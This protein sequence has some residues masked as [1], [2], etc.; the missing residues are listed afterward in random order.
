MG[1]KKEQETESVQEWQELER[2]GIVKPHPEGGAS[3]NFL[4]L[5][6]YRGVDAAAKLDEA[7]GKTAV[8]RDA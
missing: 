2:L 6:Q 5:M 8:R 3:V 1:R 7:A 4:A